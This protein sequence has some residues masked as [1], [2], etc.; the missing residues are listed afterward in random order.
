MLNIKEVADKIFRFEPVFPV[1][2]TLL[3]M[4][5]IREPDGVLIEPGPT[6]LVPHIQEAM[7]YLGIRDLAYIIP[8][9]IHVDNGGGAGKTG[10]HFSHKRGGGPPPTAPDTAH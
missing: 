3:N 4:Y 2:D 10:P 5:F 7:R 1:C 9:H 6:A 8:T